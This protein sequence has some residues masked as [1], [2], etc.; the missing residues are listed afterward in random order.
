MGLVMIGLLLARDAA[1][2]AAAKSVGIDL[3]A[4]LALPSFETGVLARRICLA[5]YPSNSQVGTFL[6]YFIFTQKQLT[7][8]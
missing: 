8:R 5:S 6:F 3:A 7:A 4:P 1:R 2:W